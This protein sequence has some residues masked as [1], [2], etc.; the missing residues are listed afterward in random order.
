MLGYLCIQQYLLATSSENLFGADNQQ[1]RP[2]EKLRGTLRDYTPD[3][4]EIKNLGIE[5]RTDVEKRSNSHQ[6]REELSHGV[7]I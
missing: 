5:M 1:G 3:P 4:R 2:R 6:N 7:K